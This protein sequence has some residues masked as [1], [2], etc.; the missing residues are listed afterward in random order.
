MVLAKIFL[1][2]MAL[3][4]QSGHAA[5]KSHANKATRTTSARIHT[6]RYMVLL[7]GG[8]LG[9]GRRYATRVPFLHRLLNHQPPPLLLH[10]RLL[11]ELPVL[12][13]GEQ[14]VLLLEDADIGNR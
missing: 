4:S 10:L 9:R 11:V 2:P 13:D 8:R 5:R 14:P 7:M 12:H 1:A 3:T 6:G